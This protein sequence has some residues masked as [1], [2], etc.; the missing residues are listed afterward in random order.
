[1][2]PV[3]VNSGDL[4]QASA[5]GPRHRTAVKD[6][7]RPDRL[8][9]D[10]VARSSRTAFEMLSA[11]SVGLEMGLSVIFGLLIG[12]WLDGRAG[13]SPW[14]TILFLGFGL[15]AGFRSVMRSVR[16]AERA[17]NKELDRG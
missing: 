7:D 5:T 12:N 1:M 3:P 17:A 13:T 4:S 14:L 2:Q 8:A 9:I 15:A 6:A 10:G 11:S 16:R